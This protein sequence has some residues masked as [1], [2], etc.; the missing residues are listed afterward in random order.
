MRGTARGQYLLATMYLSGD[1]IYVLVN[2]D[3]FRYVYIKQSIQ[4]KGFHRENEIHTGG[5]NLKNP[6]FSGTGLP[7]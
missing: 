7:G 4:Q 1:D 5:P 2:Y 3:M 6:I